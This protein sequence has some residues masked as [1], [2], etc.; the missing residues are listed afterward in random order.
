[1]SF[2]FS[3]KVSVVMPVYN[4]ENFIIE[5][6]QSVIN[7]TYKNLEIIIINDGS[8]DRTCEIATTLANQDPRI[9]IY[10]QINKGCSSAKNYG[11][12]HASGD[13]I[14]YL[15]ADDFLSEDKIQSQVEALIN[16]QSAIAVC[17]TVFFHFSKFSPI[18][19][20]NTEMLIKQG[21]GFEFLLRILG[22]EG[23]VGMVQPNAYLLPRNIVDKI[24]PWNECISP[25]PDEDSEYFARALLL[26]DNVIFTKGVNFYRKLPDLESLSQKIDQKRAINLLEGVSLTFKHIIKFEKSQRVEELYQ[27]R[28]S[29]IVYLHGENYPLLIPKAKDILKNNI[30]FNVIKIKTPFL[31]SFF[32]K[33]FG[34]KFTF[35]LRSIF[36][37]IFRYKTKNLIKKYILL[38]LQFINNNFKSFNK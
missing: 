27:S 25:S 19:E 20:I 12:S 30:Y 4:A 8:T 33:L 13:F 3:K 11:L 38:L 22:I 28:I 9:K 10:S 35:V 15:D 24:G 17:K 21:S 1:M 2:D 26:A 18:G 5:T 7:Q 14:Q 23:E 31:F 36:N 32:Y 37:K 16:S 29:Q 6:L 34:L